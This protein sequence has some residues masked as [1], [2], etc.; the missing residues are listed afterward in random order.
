MANKKFRKFRLVGGMNTEVNPLVMVEGETE[1]MLNA[2][3]DK[4]GSWQKR[5]GTTMWGDQ[6]VSGNDVL[7]IH[8]YA[9]SAGTASHQLLVVNDSA[10][11]N[12]DIF[13]IVSST[14]DGAITTSDT[15]IRIANGTEFNSSGTIEVEGDLITYT[16]KSGNDLTTVTGITSNHV[17]GLTVRQWQ[18]TNSNDRANN[19]TRFVN[20]LNRAIRVNGSDAMKAY[21]GGS[22]ETT[23]N[24]I[25]PDNAATAV[26]L[27]EVYADRLFTA[28]GSSFPDRL[29]GSS[30][31]SVS[32]NVTWSTGTQIIDRVGTTGFY[33]DINPEDGQNITALERNGNLLLIFKE[34]SLYTWDGASTQADVLVDVGA[35]SQEAVITISNITFFLGRSKK[36]LGIYAFTGG[37]PKLISRKIKRWIDN[38]DQSNLSSIVSGADDDHVYFYVGNIA[39]SNDSIYGTRTFNNVWL[40]YTLSQD[41]WSVYDDLHAQV[42]GYFVSSGKEIL[43]FGDNSGRAFEFGRGQRDDD[44]EGQTPIDMEIWTNEDPHGEPE[45]PISLQSTEVFSQ[46]AQETEVHFRYDRNPDWQDLGALGQRY[47]YFPAPQRF[48]HNIGK[49]LQFQFTNNTS[50]QAQIDGYVLNVDIDKDSRIERGTGGRSRRRG[51]T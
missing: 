47:S 8:H 5:L 1:L 49:T 33:I 20:F 40:V 26:S 3:T 42:F 39:F 50:F 18:I 2:T 7:G 28:G 13:R 19:R 14:L 31:P 51:N 16:G 4:L 23:G 36:N 21:N 45:L 44:G 29:Y 24:P 37:Y 41:S 35:V 32:G 11:T 43:V 22:W 30:M 6:A 38:I 10:D 17:T 46:L 25:N 9:N 15:T 48:E 34:R 12:S 27:I